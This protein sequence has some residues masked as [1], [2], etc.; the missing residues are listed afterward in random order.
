MDE[1]FNIDALVAA[2]QEDAQSAADIK[3]SS[4]F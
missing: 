3:T 1:V 2:R 4:R